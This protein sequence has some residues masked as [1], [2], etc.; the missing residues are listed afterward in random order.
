MSETDNVT[1]PANNGVVDLR[2]AMVARKRS[3]HCY[4][5]S[6]ADFVSASPPD[7]PCDY[8][9][10]TLPTLNGVSMNKAHLWHDR[11]SVSS[12]ARRK[13]YS[14]IISQ[15]EFHHIIMVIEES[16]KLRSSMT[17]SPLVND[18]VDG[19]FEDVPLSTDSPAS[20]RAEAHDTQH[21][22]EDPPLWKRIRSSFRRLSKR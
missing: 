3:S 6:I 16:E 8:S 13:L 2:S 10:T 4:R 14:G 7:S 18:D 20:C 22:H 19:G 12:I 15:E 1:S 17:P 5:H 11:D 9:C 21:S